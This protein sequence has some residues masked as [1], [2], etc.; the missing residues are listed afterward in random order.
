VAGPGAISTVMLYAQQA[1][2]WVD[3]G[4]LVRTCLVVAAVVW[5]CLRLA[6]PLNRALGPTGMTIV[7]RL[8]GLIL[9]AV[10]VECVIDG[11]TLLLPG[12]AAMR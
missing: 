11:V 5:G 7:T 9:A 6:A 3:A 10:A 4:L 2:G 12:L 1:T 8:M